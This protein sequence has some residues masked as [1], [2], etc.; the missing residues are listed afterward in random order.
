MEL[1]IPSQNKASHAAKSLLKGVC[2][3]VPRR[4]SGLMVKFHLLSIPPGLTEEV[5]GSCC[6]RGRN[7][8]LVSERLA[9][10]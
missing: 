4:V 2:V 6:T 1:R 8:S 3:A 7:S 5:D 10:N 9:G